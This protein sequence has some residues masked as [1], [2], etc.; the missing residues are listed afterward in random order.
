MRYR[1]LLPI[2]F[3]LLAPSL[4]AQGVNDYV[5]LHK[6]LVDLSAPPWQC[7]CYSVSRSSLISGGNSSNQVWMVERF[8]DWARAESVRDAL[9]ASPNACSACPGGARSSA[10][11]GLFVYANCG[12]SP[13]VLGVAD[14]NYSEPGWRRIAGSF[15]SHP[16]AWQHACKLHGNGQYLAPDI[17]EGVIN[18][19]SL[20]QD[21]A[22]GS[23]GRECSAFHGHWK[24]QT[25]P[26]IDIHPNGSFSRQGTERGSWSCSGNQITLDWDKGYI[27]VL[28]LSANGERM[29]GRGRRKGSTSTTHDVGGWRQ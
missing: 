22:G 27:D 18:C 5:Y 21:L 19:R 26:D 1:T 3:A 6:R 11:S 23:A 12:V 8:N 2:V 7:A 17:A 15:S 20:S 4:A 9:N 29:N 25:G 13:C 24:W 14:S 16:A 28:T 10:S